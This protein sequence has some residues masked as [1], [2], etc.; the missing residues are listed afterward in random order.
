MSQ[1]Q[2]PTLN[3]VAI[4]M[5]PALLDD[6]GRAE[7]LDFYGDVFG[8]TE[9]DNTGEAGNPL[10]LYTGA[11]AQFVYLL[12][13]DPYLRA[14]AM[15][16][17][18]VQ[19]ASLEQLQAIV[20]KAKVRQEA[21]KK[22]EEIGAPAL[23]PLRAAAASHPDVDVRLRAAVVAATIDKKLYGEV[24]RFTGHN[25]W[26]FRVVMSRDG[27]QAISVG[28]AIRV[29]EVATGNLVRSFGQGGWS[30]N[31]AASPSP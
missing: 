1:A 18:G 2:P 24:R 23:A 7:L 14:P 20:D 19:V 22:L 25:G 13:G 5:D 16:H 29:W 3:H 11:F 26:V 6:A 4:S 9:G 17:F 21:S 27:K 8:W 28:D 30:L 31:T 12:P 15:D 10:I